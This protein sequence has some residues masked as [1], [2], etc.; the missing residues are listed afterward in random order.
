M[1]KLFSVVLKFIP[2][3]LVILLGHLVRRR[4]ML[5][6]GTMQD[7]KKIIVNL[8]LPSLL[9]LTFAR[10]EFKFEYFFIFAAVFL[11]CTLA[12]LFGILLKKALNQDNRYFPAVFSGFETGM[13]GYALYSAVYGAESTYRLAIFDLGQ[14]TFVFFVLV[15]YLQRQNGKTSGV[16]GL[17]SDFLKSPVILS[18]LLGILFGSTGLTKLLEGFRLTGSIVNTLNLLGSLTEPLICL[19]IGYEL[20]IRP[21]HLLK[22]LLAVLVRMTVMVAA[23][24][25]LTRFLTEGLLHLDRGFR[26]ALFTLFLLPPPFVI[27]IY[28]DDGA[29]SEKQFVLSVLSLHVV[30]TLAAF[31]VLV[32]VAS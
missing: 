3:F 9:F 30:F 23:A 17:F 28:M 24:F 4:G 18:I 12:L 25:L 13:L 27:P 19:I 22:S 11:V 20:E 29:E 31:M 14:V 10:T 15:S 6:P 21:D 32:S 7:L 16:K 8:S 2:I 5:G 1:E 26:T